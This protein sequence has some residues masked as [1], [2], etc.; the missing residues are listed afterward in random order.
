VP[1]VEGTTRVLAG[2]QGR[3]GAPIFAVGESLDDRDE[4]LGS[5][6]TSFAVVGASAVLLASLLGYLLASIGLRPIEA[7]RRRAGG[8]SLDH[9]GERLP[10][11][12]ARD[13]VHRLAETLNEMLERL[14]RSFERERRFVADASHEL[15][16]PVAVIKTEI[17][18]TLRAGDLSPD[19]REALVAVVDEC[20][21]L[22]QLAEDLLVIARAADGKLPVRLEEIQVR[23]ALESVRERFGD[24][25]QEHRR[26]VLVATPG[27]LVV[28]ADPL[29]LRQALG[30]LTDN[31]L[32]HGAGAITLSAR[33]EDSG[34][35]IGVADEGPGFEEGVAGRAF[36][37]FARGDAA[38]TRGG[39][40]LGMAI[41]QA[42]ADAHGG[43]AE[44]RSAPNTSVVLWLPGVPEPSR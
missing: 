39:S 32:R 10:L 37:R 11:P 42:V 24:R 29:R 15:R 40:G 18:G 20:D 28:M 1:G 19:V 13:E 12:R 2:P 3:P 8:I 34:V 22:A 7:M 43:H 33:P 36:E 17:E 30:N 25:A 44:I 6:T 38:R 16:T 27:D 4:A 5:V 9:P 14:E 26:P 21:H 31:A 41:V 35:A 23:P